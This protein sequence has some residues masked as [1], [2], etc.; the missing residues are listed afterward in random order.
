MMYYA[1]VWYTTSLI[2]AVRSELHHNKQHKAFHYPV[3]WIHSL[4]YQYVA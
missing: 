4:E 2:S 1:V 3:I